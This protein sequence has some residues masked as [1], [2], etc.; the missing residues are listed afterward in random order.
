MRN[1]PR[2]LRTRLAVTAGRATAALSKQLGQGEGSVIGGRVSLAIEPNSLDLLSKGR[3]VVL[4]SGTNGKTTTTSLLTAAL[5]T[6]GPVVSNVAGANMFAGMVSALSASDAKRAVLEVDEGHLPLA[7]SKT[8]AQMVVLLNLSRD[9]LDRVGEVRMQAQK[10]RKALE[11]GEVKVVANCD[12]PMVVWAAGSENTIWVAGGS[13]WRLDAASCPDCGGHIEW[14][15]QD[16]QVTDWRCVEC[17]LR[18]PEPTPTKVTAPAT[19][20]LPGEVN[21]CNAI[22]AL[23]AAVELGADPAESAGA[24]AR[25]DG[26]GGR[27]ARVKIAGAPARLLL[28]KN[29]AGWTEALRIAKQD[30]SPL[31][32]SINARIQDGRD[33][34]WLWDVPYEQLKGRFIVATGERGRDLAVRL[35]YAGVDHHFVDQSNQAVLA[36]SQRNSGKEVDVIGNYSAFQ[37]FRKLVGA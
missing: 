10:W 16:T 20:K 9:Q 11:T 19:L 7:L 1:I 18:R 2:S 3:T 28:A 15:S 36:A 30:G 32:I 13:V 22:M 29:P 21:R 25:L 24:V 34:S 27:F 37:E 26:T 5:E 23:T 6:M 14:K 8:G 12:D 4:V 17:D 35:H 33:P 31:V